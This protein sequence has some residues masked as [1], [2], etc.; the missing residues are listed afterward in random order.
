MTATSATDDPTGHLQ[1]PTLSPLL[2]L[3]RELRDE[4]YNYYFQAN[5]NFTYDFVTNKLKQ[6]DGLSIPLS[7]T[8][9]C[10]QIHEEV[11]GL[12]LT[13]NTIVF[14]TSF[15]ETTRESAALFIAEDRVFA[16]V[17]DLAPQLLSK[18]MAQIVAKLY[19]QFAPILNNWQPQGR[20]S[21]FQLP[22]ITWGE[23][24]SIWRDFIHLVLS[25]IAQDPHFMELS[26]VARGGF[27][28][29]N[30]DEALKL[31]GTCT[32]PWLI[33]SATELE[34]MV[35]TAQAE[36]RLPCY[37]PTTRYTCS[38][39]SSAIR[40]LRSISRTTRA[41]IRNIQVLEDRECVAS[42]ECHGRG[43]VPFCQENPKLRLTH[44]VNLWKNAFPVY[45]SRMLW[46]EIVCLLEVSPNQSEPG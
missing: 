24:P 14:T 43:F 4:T 13:L 30:G 35:N 27:N 11:Q 8:L 29:Y 36:L 3:P 33:P 17:N 41:A 9:V 32:Q 5:D 1:P 7:L 39:A 28:G 21:H 15:D 40:F 44:T 34:E 42:P 22:K 46:T 25:L 2:Q 37:S 20:I 18:E 38:A 45:C 23:P 26:H 12:A 31:V 16:I 19:P 10:R 6:A